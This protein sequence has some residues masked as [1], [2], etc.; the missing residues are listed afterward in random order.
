M[1]DPGIGH[2]YV[3][4]SHYV[5]KV[6]IVPKQT[7]FLLSSGF[8]YPYYSFCF[9]SGICLF[10]AL[11]GALSVMPWLALNSWAQVIPLPQPPA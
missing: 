6:F 10:W 8:P 1:Q 9:V 11:L 3:D 2:T 7:P 4:C 5:I